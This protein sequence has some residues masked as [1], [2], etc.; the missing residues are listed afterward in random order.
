M[1]NVRQTAQVV[2][3]QK[4]RRNAKYKTKSG[5]PATG[6]NQSKIERNKNRRLGPGGRH[7]PNR[8]R[9]APPK[10][11]TQGPSLP[12]RRQRPVPLR[13]WKQDWEFFYDANEL[14]KKT[15][16]VQLGIF[17]NCAGLAA[18]E[19]YSHFEWEEE[20]DKLKLEKII[21]KFDKFCIPRENAIVERYN[22]YKRSQQPGES[23]LQ[24]VSALRTLAATCKFG[25]NQD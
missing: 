22:F 18:Q 7:S 16:K 5:N 2:G 20:G 6:G 24:F 10:A 8:P 1:Q 17:F 15:D 4:K 12:R 11:G 21:E 3:M 13:G 19:K 25:Q 9:P 14:G 23:V